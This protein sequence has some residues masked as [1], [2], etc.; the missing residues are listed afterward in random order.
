MSSFNKFNDFVNQLAEKT[1]NLNADDIRV[2]L[3]NAAPSPSNTVKAN[4]AE[5]TAEHGYAAGGP[6]VTPVWT[7]PSGV[8]T[9]AG[10][11]P[12]VTASG[13]T[14]GPFRYV[15]FYNNTPAGKNLIGWWDYGSSITLADTET[16]TLQF[17]ANILTIT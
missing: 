9:L 10:T 6:S 17:G 2:Y 13:G 5:I 4:I 3:S 1:H 8:G 12:V 16:F 15:I 14:V 7:C 11:N